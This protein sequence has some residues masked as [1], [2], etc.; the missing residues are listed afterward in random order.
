MQ[1]CCLTSSIVKIHDFVFVKHYVPV[2]KVVRLAILTQRSKSRSQCQ[3]PWCH[4][5]GHHYLSMDAKYR[6]SISYG[7]KVLANAKVDNIQRDRQTN[8]ETKQKQYAPIRGHTKRKAKFP[9]TMR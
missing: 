1:G 8:K 5:K 7:S 6:V 2:R 9:H 3:L 4:L